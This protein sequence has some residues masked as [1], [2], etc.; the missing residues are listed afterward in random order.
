MATKTVV[1]T[2][3]ASQQ[4]AGANLLLKADGNDYAD[5]CNVN[6]TPIG[7][8]THSCDANYVQTVRALSPAIVTLTASGAIAFGADVGLAANGKVCAWTSGLKLG[9]AVSSADAD[10]DEIEVALAVS[11]EYSVSPSGVEVAISTT[12]PTIPP[13]VPSGKSAFALHYTTS[14][15]GL[16]FWNGSA[17]EQLV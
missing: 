6:D 16:Y 10:G 4:I 5:L 12:V 2:R 11:S 13:G 17:W 15:Q 7:V 8:S 9:K 1:F 3:L 14:F